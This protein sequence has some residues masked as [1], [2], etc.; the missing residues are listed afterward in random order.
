MA[1]ELMFWPLAEEALVRLE[2]DRLMSHVLA[3]V[4]RTL[5]RL[6]EDPYEPRLGTRSF[7]TEA[8]GGVSATTVRVDSWYVIWQPGPSSSALEIILIHS[9]DI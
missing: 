9:I 1:C 6:E 7:V 5:D 2:G 8:Y 3:A 4:N